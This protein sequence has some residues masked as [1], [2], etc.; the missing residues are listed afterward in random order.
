MENIS[1]RFPHGHVQFNRSEN[2]NKNFFIE[3]EWLKIPIMLISRCFFN[4]L[5]W[6]R[7][8]SRIFSG[9]GGVWDEFLEGG[10]FLARN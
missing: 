9:G 2:V 1:D 6:C 3:A 10:F 7:G 4:F 8:G 5:V